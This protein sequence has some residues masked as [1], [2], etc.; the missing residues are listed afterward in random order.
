[1][2]HSVCFTFRRV[3]SPY[4]ALL[5][6]RQSRDTTARRERSY[7][8]K[9]R[10]RHW[11]EA[12]PLLTSSTGLGALGE[13][14]ILPVVELVK[15][16]QATQEAICL[17][18]VKFGSLPVAR[19]C[20]TGALGRWLGS[21]TFVNGQVGH[22]LRERQEHLAPDHSHLG[23]HTTGDRAGRPG[24]WDEPAVRKQT[25]G[26][27]EKPQAGDRR[28]REG[29]HPPCHWAPGRSQDVLRAL[30]PCPGLCWLLQ[31]SSRAHLPVSGWVSSWVSHEPPAG[32]YSSYRPPAFSQLCTHSGGSSEQGTDF[33]SLDLNSSPPASCEMLAIL[34]AD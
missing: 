2:F 30:P 18:Q 20:V 26:Q 33:F 23:P 10:G 1:M 28:H 21:F 24:L 9:P 31:G 5:D 15:I 12:Y 32:R 8:E 25:R 11:S 14:L 6:W 7:S 4:L 29:P 27:D 34:T 16:L 22:G 17:F 3:S 13:A 19:S